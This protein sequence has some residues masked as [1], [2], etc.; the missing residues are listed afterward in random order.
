M[1]EIIRTRFKK[2]APWESNRLGRVIMISMLRKIAEETERFLM[3]EMFESDH[4]RR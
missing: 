1:M 4:P 2:T 3:K